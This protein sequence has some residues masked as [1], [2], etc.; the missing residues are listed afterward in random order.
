MLISWSASLDAYKWCGGPAVLNQHIFKVAEKR[1]LI[2]REYL[3]FAT[4]QAMREIRLQ[5]HGATMRHITKPE[6]EAIQIPLPP[7]EEQKRIAAI[8]NEQMAAVERARAAAEAQLEAAKALPAAYLRAVF[9]SPESQQWPRKPLR[10]LCESDGQYGTSEKADPSG[11]GLPVL[12]MG[13][14]LDGRIL[15]DDLKFIQLPK[16]EEEKYRLVKGDLLFNRTN[17]AEL[18]GKTA[19]Y[20]GS[21][22]AVFA[23][24]LIRFRIERTRADSEFVCS[25]INSEC[26][27]RFI[28]QNMA[29]AIGQVNISAS[30]MHR[31]PIPLPPLI[32]QQRIAAMLND[33]MASAEQVRKAIEEELDAI[34]KLPAALL[35]RAFNGEL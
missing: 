4:R 12:R 24:Y 28:E 20:D 10:E 14:I 27:R 15:W 18:V 5:V 3:Y 22:D 16:V 6:F 21:H 33:Q 13:N 8:L 1:E 31:M 9:S 29:R 30:T 26:G 17:S 35:R 25:Y 11:V 19:V 32:N 34:N 23:S 7:L 2:R